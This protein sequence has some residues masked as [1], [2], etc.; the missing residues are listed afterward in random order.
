M[1]LLPKGTTV[2]LTSVFDNTASNP[3]NP[4]P[5]QWLVEGSR[6][7][8]EMHNMRLGITFVS[9]EEFQRL[10][11]EKERIVSAERE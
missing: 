1:P 5:D 10:L 9:D 6:T 3:Y 2:I 11:A 7:A 4:D 8:D